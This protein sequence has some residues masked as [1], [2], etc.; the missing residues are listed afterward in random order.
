MIPR[1]LKNFTVVV[2]GRGYAGKAEEVKLPKLTIKTE[3][4]RGGGMDMPVK[5]DMGM[6]AMETELTFLEYNEEVFKLFGLRSLAPVQLTLRGA[7][8]DEQGN[9]TGVT[10][11]L[12]G[13]WEELDFGSWKIGD[14]ATLKVKVTLTYYK[15]NMGNV[16]LIEIDAQ[17]MIRIINGV[18][19]LAEV[20][21]LLGV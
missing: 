21:A 15:L 12:R 2:D 13:K 11:N 5:I 18:D 3:E 7:L 20:R 4:Y 8:D 10:V 1:V 16:D 17:N 9:L 19:Q 14:K 6:E